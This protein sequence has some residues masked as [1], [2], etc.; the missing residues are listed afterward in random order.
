MSLALGIGAAGL[1]LGGVSQI[2]NFYSQ[3]RNLD[4]QKDLQR[5]IFNREDNSIQRRVADLK[6]AGLSPVLAA[7]QGANAGSVIRTDAPQIE[8]N[9]LQNAM[10][11]MTMQENIDNTKAQRDLI[12][13]QT[14]GA[15]ADAGIK[16]HDLE[17][18]RKTGTTS[19][20]GALPN[21][22]RNVT[23]ITDSPIV[24]PI[25]EA[26]KDKALWDEV[27]EYL[28]PKRI[29]QERKNKE[30]DDRE[31]QRIKK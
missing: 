9:P 22:F 1:A 11:L 17:I 30:Y 6:S 23:G 5:D 31:L 8:G 14:A 4:Y 29:I 21:L 7:G 15:R 20:A 12:K 10:Q 19:N 26:V 27:E 28:I 25:K 24:Q 13:A 16:S 2:A 3:Y 18:F